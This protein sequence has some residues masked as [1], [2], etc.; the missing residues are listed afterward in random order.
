MVQFIFIKNFA[1]AVQLGLIKTYPHA[2]TA[3]KLFQ[4]VQ[5]VWVPLT[6]QVVFQVTIFQQM[7]LYVAAAL[8]CKVVLIAIV[9]QIARHACLD[10]IR[11]DSFV[12]D[13]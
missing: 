12:L 9:Q 11:M 13:A 6:V 3:R 4:D 10:T 1:V 5:S 2:S 7:P 8:S